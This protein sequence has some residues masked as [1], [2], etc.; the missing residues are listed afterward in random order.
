[1][2][3]QIEQICASLGV[4]RRVFE[5]SSDPDFR[6]YFEAREKMYEW[7]DARI[8]AWAEKATKHI[9]Q[10]IV[11]KGFPELFWEPVFLCSPRGRMYRRRKEPKIK[12]M[13]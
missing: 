10:Q 5:G 3:E 11:E 13:W 1:M 7:R 9:V 4:P 6:A 12:I 8:R 2:D